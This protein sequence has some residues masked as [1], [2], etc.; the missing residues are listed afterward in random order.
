MFWLIYPC[1]IKN[2][3]VWAVILNDREVLKVNV[4]QEKYEDTNGVIRNCKL[5][6][7]QY[8]GVI[9]NCK[10]EDRQHNGVI[11]NCKLED[12]QYNG[13]NQKL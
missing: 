6:D 8:N 10:L 11:R 4:S 3:I 12:R 5:E 7:R 9:R 2:K 1:Q 13:G